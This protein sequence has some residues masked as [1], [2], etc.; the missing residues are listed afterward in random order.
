MIR[1][2]LAAAAAAV[3]LVTPVG[4]KRAIRVFTPIE[5]LIRADAVVVGKVTA[6]EK[7]TVLAE[8]SP[9]VKEKQTYKVAVIKIGTGLVGAAN[10][11]HV[12]VAFTPAPRNEPPAVGPGFPKPP[13]RGGF[14]PV[15]LTEGMEG[16]FYLTK[17]HSGEF[18]VINPIMAPIE[19]KAEGYKEQVAL[20]KKGAEVLTE[21]V[22]SLKAEKADDRAF[23]AIVMIGKYRSYPENAGGAKVENEKVPAEESK[24]VLKALAEAN[25]KPNPND[26]NAPNAYQAF[27]QLG[28]NDKDGWKY[29]MVKPGEDFIDKTKQAFV[30]WLA[31]PGK[32]YQL[33]RFV[34]KK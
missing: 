13:G 22:K 19:A 18:Y 20:A 1:C 16:L 25:W 21:P 30:A 29:P 9:G 10:V 6:I 23:A 17:H 24:L 28:L 31:G 15:A 2:F 27:S 7:D 8:P 14:G 5:K 12:K 26:A 33:S 11:T 4:A 34:L 3:V 32:D